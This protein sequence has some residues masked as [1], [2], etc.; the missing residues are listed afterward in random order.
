MK[1]KDIIK[2]L[3]SLPK[4]S[5]PYLTV[6]DNETHQRRLEETR[7]IKREAKE[8]GEIVRVYPLSNDS[9]LY[10]F[11][12]NNEPVG[13]AHKSLAWNELTYY[14]YETTQKTIKF[15]RQQGKIR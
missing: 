9:K 3:F 7:Q 2:S 11:F 5:I 13:S 6:T 4:V 1:F 10:V 14:D 8:R 12:K 15:W